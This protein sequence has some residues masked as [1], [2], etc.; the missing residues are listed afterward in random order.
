[1]V[2]NPLSFLTALLM[3]GT[4]FAAVDVNTASEAEL[5][6]IKGIGPGLSGRILAE[7]KNAPFKDWADLTGRVAGVGPRSAAIF[8]R[9]G[10]TV[11]GQEY[12]A[13]ASASADP[14]RPRKHAPPSQRSI[15]DNAPPLPAEP[16]A[17]AASAG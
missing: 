2:K 6:S 8:S 3:A 4:V 5:D 9:E 17:P 7:R 1:M 16:P 11:N 10:L 14:K 15:G 13:G 12:S